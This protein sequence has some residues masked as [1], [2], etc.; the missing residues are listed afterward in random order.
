M[1][2][3]DILAKI[4]KGEALTDAEKAFLAEADLDKMLNDAAAAARRKAEEK[5]SAAEQKLKDAEAKAKE[6]SDAAEAQGD[7]GKTELEKAQKT[8]ERLTAQLAE[9]DAAI[10]TLSTEKEGLTREQKLTAIIQKS[11]IAF[12]PGVNAV[13][14]T[15]LF[16]SE[17]ADIELK[18]LDDE[19]LI[20]PIVSGF[21]KANEAIIA[22]E[23]GKGSG[24]PPNR[25]ET[26]QG[27]KVANP[28]KKETLNVTLQ[29]KILS[30]D[31]ELAKRMKTEAGIATA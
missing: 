11:G 9:R 27:S 25:S 31:P 22:D 6:L 12:I 17:F 19:A 20:K 13:A 21:V 4:A 23:T 29:G 3:K 26:F 28:W 8:I 15:K 24:R 18:D 14:M 16:K 1:N 10:K 30:G 2:L 5:L 7:K